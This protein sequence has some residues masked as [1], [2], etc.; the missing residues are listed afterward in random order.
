MASYSR[1]DTSRRLNGQMLQLPEFQELRRVVG[2]LQQDGDMH[3]MIEQESRRAVETLSGQVDRLRKA[4]GIMS[5]VM[6]EELEGLQASVNE[7]RQVARNAQAELQMAR[8]ERD[9][10]RAELARM[11]VEMAE[12]REETRA[13]MARMRAELGAQLAQV[14]ASQSRQV[15]E[16]QELMDRERAESAEHRGTLAHIMDLC[17]DDI[18]ALDKEHGALRSAVDKALREEAARIDA[19]QARMDARVG[20]IEAKLAEVA[21]THNIHWQD[22]VHGLKAQSTFNENM[23][24]SLEAMR[25]FMRAQA[26]RRSQSSGAAAY[27]GGG[28]SASWQQRH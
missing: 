26:P 8:D 7:S 23:E 12:E 28:A 15:A 14:Q 6:M 18:Y 13:E 20:E 21:S 24:Q 11:R 3:L 27:T 10:A 16:A 4:L 19:L 17:N 1:K 5:D 25:A 9:E 22:I 2:A